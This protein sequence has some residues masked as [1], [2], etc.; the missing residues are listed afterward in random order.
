META[1]QFIAAMPVTKT[2]RNGALGCGWPNIPR[3][4]RA[5]H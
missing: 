4:L 2:D 1:R 3:D 5:N